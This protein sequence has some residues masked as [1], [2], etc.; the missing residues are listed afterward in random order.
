MTITLH[1]VS[2]FTKNALG[3]NLAGVV[4]DADNL[5][6]DQ[7][8]QIAS[9]LGYSETVF[10]SAFTEETNTPQNVD[11][12]ISFFT[13]TEEVAF[14]GHATLALFYLLHQ[15]QR[16][17]TGSYRFITQAGIFT[18]TI[19]SNGLV[20]MQQQLPKRLKGF[21]AQQIA[22]MLNLSTEQLSS[23][24]PIEALSTGLC[25]LI[26]PV[27]LGIL[28]NITPDLTKITAFCSTHDIVGLH[29]FEL[30]TPT[31]AI[32]ANCRNFAPLVGIEE[33]SATGSACG[34][35]ACYLYQHLQQTTF[36][37]EQGA[38]M[39]SPSLLQAKVVVDAGNI[40]RVEVSGFARLIK[41]EQYQ[42]VESDKG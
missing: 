16:I 28:D 2:A 14:C 19:A 26:I 37:F 24:L 33:E 17:T 21:S 27:P 40:K 8:Q 29:L 38:S 3:G 35:L 7:K 1:T 18:V 34:A 12:S 10:L 13:P 11:F 25:D 9:Y 5:S 31:N 36:T 15:Q 30:N 42:N 22:P 32:T 6:R 23:T 39:D 41:T 4:F 20:T